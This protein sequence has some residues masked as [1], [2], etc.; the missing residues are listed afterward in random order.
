MKR[1]TIEQERAASAWEKVSKAHQQALDDSKRALQHSDAS[2]KKEF[3]DK[4]RDLEKNP[5]KFKKIY[6]GLARSLPALVQTDGLG[7]ALAFL[8][9]KGQ[10]KVWEA[11]TRIYEHVSQWVIAQLG[12]RNLNLEGRKDLLEVICHLDSRI[13]RMA[14]VESLAYLRWLK[15]FAEAELPAPEG[16][17]KS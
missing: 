5:D 8:C 17:S 9:A 16:G 15:R 3:E 7:Q 2:R 12:K 11:H 6:S 13:Y 14:V 10:K 1:Q 4:V